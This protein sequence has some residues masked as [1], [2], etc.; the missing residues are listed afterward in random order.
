MLSLCPKRRRASKFHSHRSVV[1]FLPA[2]KP[3]V[4]QYWQVHLIGRLEVQSLDA[5]PLTVTEGKKTCHLSLRLQVLAL[6]QHDWGSWVS[7]PLRASRQCTAWTS[8]RLLAELLSYKYADARALDNQDKM[9]VGCYRAQR[10]PAS[11]HQGASLHSI[12]LNS[13]LYSVQN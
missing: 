10:R 6:N 12:S 1:Q 4:C 9:D 5:A 11:D 3:P 13:Y 7:A 2:T 8:S